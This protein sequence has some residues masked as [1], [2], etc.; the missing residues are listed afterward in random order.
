MHAPRMSL[1]LRSYRG[2]ERAHAHDFHQIVLPVVGAM[3]VRVGDAVG[4][5]ASSSGALIVSGTPHQG[6]VLGENRFVVFE[7]P[8]ATFLPESIVA[9]AS[10]APFFPIDDPLDHLARYVSSEASSGTLG[11]GLAHHAAALLADSI[12]RKFSARERHAGPIL[13]ALA[14]IE[15]RY[16]EPLTVAELARAAGMAASRFHEHFRRETGHTPAERLA[17]T[18]L[19][20]AEDLLR[21]T[22][23]S[24]AEIALAVGFSDQSALTRSFR[25]RRGTTPAALRWSLQ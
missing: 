13:R 20:R 2:R 8:R 17:M 18:R 25:R 14:I 5:I 10:E 6:N 15:E 21:E 24:I 22:R 1:S 4:A 11:G 3:E 16:A 12:G 23:L 7:V 9:C 19:D